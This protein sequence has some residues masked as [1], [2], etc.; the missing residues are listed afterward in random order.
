LLSP[1]EID[2]VIWVSDREAAAGCREL[3]I[4]EGILAGGS[5]GAVVAAISKLLP[6]LPVSAEIVAILPDRGERYLD[7]VYDDEWCEALPHL[8]DQ[9]AFPEAPTKLTSP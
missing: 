7:L 4:S 8:L 5:S 2:D 6:Q 3:A 9:A 1:D